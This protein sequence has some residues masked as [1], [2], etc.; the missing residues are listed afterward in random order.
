VDHVSVVS[1]VK[2][3][4]LA[5]PVL[6]RTLRNKHGQHLKPF[7]RKNPPPW[8]QLG[9]TGLDDKRKCLPVPGS[10]QPRHAGARGA[11]RFEADTMAADV[12]IHP[13]KWVTLVKVREV[14]DLH[15]LFRC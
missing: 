5:D 15:Q 9:Q 10:R 7:D 6:N 4:W 11:S 1:A 12:Y 2:A 13:D 3:A 8:M 14:A